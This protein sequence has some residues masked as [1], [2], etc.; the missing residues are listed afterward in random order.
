M[1]ASPARRIVLM[2]DCCFS[3]AFTRGMRTRDGGQ[4]DVLERFTGRGRTVITATNA[5]EYAFEQDKMLDADP[6]P[7]P[8]IFDLGA[9]QGLHRSRFSQGVRDAGCVRWVETG[10]L[11]GSHAFQEVQS[12]LAFLVWGR[13]LRVSRV[14]NAGVAPF[15][16]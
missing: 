10:P 3:G 8:S 1:E 5:M 4:V 12:H 14:Q 9:D 13:T 6:A 11:E 16:L 2:L 15:H 7:V